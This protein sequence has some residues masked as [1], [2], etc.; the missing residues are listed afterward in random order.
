M[1]QGKKP[2]VRQRKLMQAWKINWENWLVVKDAPN[3]MV[4][5]HR[6]TDQTRTIPKA[7]CSE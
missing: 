6:L 5:R 7:R 2:N 1:R 4:I 3:E